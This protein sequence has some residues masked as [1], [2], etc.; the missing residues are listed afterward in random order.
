M[1][2]LKA[3][4]IAMVLICSFTASL[5]CGG[6]CIREAAATVLNNS[7]EIMSGMAENQ[8][9]EL[10]ECLSLIAQSVDSFAGVCMKELKDFD[11]FKKDSDYV[12]KYTE[13]MLPI[14]EQ[15]ALNTRGALT[16]YVRYN[17][18]FTE[19]TSGIFLTRDDMDNDFESITPTD[20]SQYDPDDAEHVGW[21]YIPVN[22][23]KPTWM[24]PY[25]NANINVYMIS[26]VIPLFI[27]GESVG[28]VGMDIDFSM[29]QEQIGQIQFWKS[30]YAF[31]TNSTDNILYH[32]DIEVGTAL[33]ENAEFQ[34][35]VKTLDDADAQGKP[36]YYDYKGKKKCMIY[37]S[38]QNGMKLVLTA[39]ESELSSG[40]SRLLVQAI[41]A[42]VIAIVL[43]LIVGIAISVRITKPLKRITGIVSRTAALD[44]APD[45]NMGYLCKL[46]DETGGIARAVDKMQD[47]LRDMIKEIQSVNDGMSASM[48]QLSDATS[49]VAGI[50]NDNSATTQELAATMEETAATTEGI[51]KNVEQINEHAEYITRLSVEGD[52][53]S[54]Q[55]HER[56]MHLQEMTGK[57]ADKTQEMYE[58]LNRESEEAL[59]RSKAV[60]KIGE[61]TSAITEISSQTSLLALNASIEAARAGE[62]GKGFAVVAT[63]IG[64]LANQ[65]LETVTNIDSIVNEAFGSVKIMG[66]CLAS[67]TSFLE[68]TV[69]TDYS[70]FKEVSEQYTND[71]VLFKESMEKIRGSVM[72]L[73]QKMDTVTQAV[74]SISTAVTEAADGISNIAGKTSEM[75]EN[76]SQ[77]N[78][79]VQENRDNVGRLESVVKQFK[80]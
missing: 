70:E 11:T 3:K 32:K 9:T 80:L 68:K 79:D 72:D 71:A 49:Q 67:S 31:L 18:E 14:A 1:R 38:L 36:G 44:F 75:V 69:L 57:A 5:I 40:V 41:V 66:E 63:E 15:F 7:E 58:S 65:T 53:M 19:P 45:S 25:L 12:N 37:E 64:N 61:M 21:Y 2:S 55:V 35:M 78:R 26:Y 47:C 23:G 39:P 52:E 28:I 54:Q 17:P 62:A 22:N 27:D 74:A 50:C 16:C 46:K 43:S 13:R 56:A 29:I 6:L 60:D 42:G 51:Y 24:D 20:F 10:D 30:G 48:A 4:I 76:V 77:T 8:Q 59:R 73:S 33:S 34:G